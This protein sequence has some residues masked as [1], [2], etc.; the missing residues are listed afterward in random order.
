LSFFFLGALLSLSRD[1]EGTGVFYSFYPSGGIY[2]ME[3]A[4][5]RESTFEKM[6][7]ILGSSIGFFTLKFWPNEDLALQGVF[8]IS[9]TMY[10]DEPSIER[11]TCI[12]VL[13][14]AYAWCI[15]TQFIAAWMH[16]C[17][18]LAHILCLSMWPDS[19]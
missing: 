7:R 18:E 1:S 19:I 3:P 10:L 2:Y 8:H 17:A 4:K 13:Q 14:T 12:S 15:I 11:K 16:T 5:S 6:Q 9:Y